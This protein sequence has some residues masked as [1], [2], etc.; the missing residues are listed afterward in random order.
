M[1]I[2][3]ASSWRNPFQPW[4]VEELRKAGNETYDFR[5]PKEGDSGFD[6]RDTGLKTIDGQCLPE[7]LQR[8]LKQPRAVEGFTS[9]F[10]AMKWADACVLVLPC[11]NSAH[12]EAGWMAGAGKKTFVFATNVLIVPE[13]MYGLLGR[14]YLNL[15]ELKAA[16]EAESVS[17]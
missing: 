10:D 3:V 8:A 16:L 7:H 17:S 4:V 12:L 15:D 6:W 1:K 2:Y 11:G 14:M 9:D 13:L 5:N